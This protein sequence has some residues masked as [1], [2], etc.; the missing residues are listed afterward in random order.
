M[1]MKE[2][3]KQTRSFINNGLRIRLAQSNPKHT[4]SAAEAF[5][6]AIN[7]IPDDV[8]NFLIDN[9]DAKIQVHKIKPKTDEHSNH[10]SHES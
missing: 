1:N 5:K 7:Q 6:S 2:T 4:R 10:G 9:P 8:I 3:I